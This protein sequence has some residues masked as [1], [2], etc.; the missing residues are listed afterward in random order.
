MELEQDIL[1]RTQNNCL[2]EKKPVKA[3]SKRSGQ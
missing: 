1:Y 3:S 2:K